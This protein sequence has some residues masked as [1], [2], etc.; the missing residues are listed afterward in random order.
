MNE[1]GE[2][3]NKDNEIALDDFIRDFENQFVQF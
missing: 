2:I 3:T 1:K